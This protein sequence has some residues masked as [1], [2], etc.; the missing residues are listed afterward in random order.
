[1]PVLV[2][3]N[4][5]VI[6]KLE[7]EGLFVMK[8]KRA[9]SQDIRPLKIALANLMPSKIST[10]LQFLRLLSNSP[11][12][13]EIT[14]LRMDSHT[15]KHT[16][17]DYLKQFY[18]SPKQIE[19]QRFDGMIITGAPVET[20][21]FEQVDYWPEICALMDYTRAHVFSTMYICWGAQAGLYHHY[22]IQ[23]HLL[24]KKC[25]GVFAH[26]PHEPHHLLLKGADSQVFVPHSRH[27]GWKIKD[28]ENH[29][30]LHIALDAKEAGAC[31]VMAH[32]ARQI[33]ISGH[34]EYDADTLANEY[35][36]DLKKGMAI[37]MP[38][39][40]FKDNDPQKGSYFNWRAHANLIFSN[41]LNYIVYQRTPFDLNDLTRI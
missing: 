35:F 19:H 40:Y 22:G 39:H 28:I 12:Q 14:L 11:L 13:I 21:A 15:S 31:I 3:N 5:P 30:D 41:W 38:K 32:E 4:L 1:M 23:K 7:Q 16:D 18:V 25:F 8:S 29:P 17:N 37:Q 9:A 26:T 36:R 34:F 27:S 20:M 2:K 33:F 24:P 6:E 10:E